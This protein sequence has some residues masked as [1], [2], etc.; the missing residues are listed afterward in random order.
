MIL[1]AFVVMILPLIPYE[2]VQRIQRR[3]RLEPS[4]L[5]LS[6]AVVRLD[7]QSF[8]IRL[9]YGDLHRFA[10]SQICLLYTSRCV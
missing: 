4:D 7:G 1:S 5:L 6:D 8:A 9:V 3:T 2:L 10:W